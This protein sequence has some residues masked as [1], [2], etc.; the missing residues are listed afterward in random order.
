MFTED[1]VDSASLQILRATLLVIYSPTG[2]IELIL[3]AVPSWVL[4]PSSCS[5]LRAG[6][7]PEI[8]ILTQ[9][10]NQA[11]VLFYWSVLNSS[12]SSG[13][14]SALDPPGFQG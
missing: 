3:A 14:G 10:R 1:A 6:F 12:I 4:H 5:C 7:C 11:P 2:L 8:P 13:I 9:L